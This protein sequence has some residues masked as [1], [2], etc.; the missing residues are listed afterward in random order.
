ME[1][2]KTLNGHERKDIANK[3]IYL[4]YAKMRCYVMKIQSESLNIKASRN[5]PEQA[6][7]C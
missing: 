7:R 5:L 3:K 2:G 6:R 4:Q 1:L